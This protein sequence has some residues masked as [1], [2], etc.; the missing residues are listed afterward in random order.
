MGQTS[1]N[2]AFGKLRLGCRCA[3]RVLMALD[4]SLDRPVGK[5]GK[6]DRRSDVVATWRGG[7]RAWW[8][9]WLG[10]DMAWWRHGVVVTLA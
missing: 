4:R 7:D 9:H 3:Q 5:P 6:N 2:G 8:R 10:G 1:R